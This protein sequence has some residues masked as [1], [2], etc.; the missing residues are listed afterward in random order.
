MLVARVVIHEAS[1]AASTCVVVYRASKVSVLPFTPQ[2]NK[3]STTQNKGSR[4]REDRGS[5]PTWARDREREKVG[6]TARGAKWEDK[7]GA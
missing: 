1:S 3:P 6:D 2:P 7:R 5:V 4:R